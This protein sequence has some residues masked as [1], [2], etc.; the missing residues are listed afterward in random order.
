MLAEAH[1]SVVYEMSKLTR[2]A[3][4][5][6]RQAKILKSKLTR[7]NNP[8]YCMFCVTNNCNSRCVMCNFW[9]NKST[10]ELTVGEI[11]KLFSS[12]IF[13]NLV[14]VAITGG[15][16]L[17]RQDIE[18]VIQVIYD[19]TH[20]KPSLSTNGFLPKRLKTLLDAKHK[21]ISE[22]G[23]SL[24]GLQET[25]DI[26]RGIKDGFDKVNESLKLIKSYGLK[27]SVNMTLFNKNAGEL[28]EMWQIYKNDNFSYKVAQISESY[29]GNNVGVDLGLSEEVK[30]KILEQHEKINSNNLYDVFL[31]DWIRHGKRPLPCYAGKYE[32]YIDALGNIYPCIHKPILG[33]VRQAQP[34]RIWH[35]QKT[36]ELRKVYRN[37]QDCYERCTVSTF[38]VDALKWR[39]RKFR[40]YGKTT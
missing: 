3:A 13:K 33:N 25:H 7:S 11:G 37:C 31:G 28:L 35:S 26:I 2:Y 14:S 30:K 40:K 10:G 24:D 27:A 23:L 8:L 32:I 6:V 1:G 39:A 15:E 9:K 17:V 20:V 34:E 29:Y 38:E 4:F 19:K 12:K 21:I 18:E 16:P 5:G 22:V 36:N